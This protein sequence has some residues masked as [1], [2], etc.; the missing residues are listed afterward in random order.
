MK[1]RGMT[2]RSGDTIPHVICVRK[3]VSASNLLAER[4]FH[5]DELTKDPDLTIDAEWYLSSQIHPPVARLCEFIQG[6]DASKLAACLGLDAKK[7]TPT[8]T[9]SVVHGETVRLLSKMSVEERMAGVERGLPLACDSCKHQWQCESITGKHDG[10]VCPQCRKPVSAVALYNTLLVKLRRH[11]ALYYANW[12]DCNQCHGHYQIVRVYEH[13]CPAEEC[14]GRLTPTYPAHRLYQQLLHY[15]SIF[16]IDRNPLPDRHQDP[17]GWAMMA[18][19]MREVEEVRRLAELT[20]QQCAY[21]IINLAA[22]FS[23]AKRNNK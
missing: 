10:A 13:K 19:L 22:I 14:S 23:F 21:P 18:K 5:P 9:T 12:Q 20:V 3:G 2:V 1:Q 8:E 4:A 15:R 6:T 7:Y 16:E 17:E 11:Q